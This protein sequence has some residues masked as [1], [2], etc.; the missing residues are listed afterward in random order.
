[1]PPAREITKSKQ[2]LVEG[3]DAEIFFQAFLNQLGLSDFQ[4]Q[5][6]GGISELR[7]FL[8]ALSIT[9]DFTSIVTSV[10]IIRDAESNASNAFRSA[11]GALERVGLDVPHQPLTP[12]TGNPLVNICILPCN[13][14]SGM[15]ET[16][17]LQTVIHDPAM[18]CIEQ[19]FQCLE[20]QLGKLPGNL[21]KA[22]I[23]AFLA[24]RNKSGLRLGEAAHK[25][26]WIWSSPV[27][28]PVK[29]FL[30]SL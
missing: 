9:P 29:D 28:E 22:K 8:K 17:C 15:L 12:T 30:Q 3:R 27:L 2:L 25:G 4:I 26:Y 20:R 23:Q 13:E 24:S 16:L 19:Y 21:P 10:G 6:F 18:M 1:M 14:V 11:C 5:N 7:P